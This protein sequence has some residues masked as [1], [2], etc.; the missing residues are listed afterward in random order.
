MKAKGPLG[1]GAVNFKLIGYSIVEPKV[2]LGTD[3][4]MN[5]I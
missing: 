4:K 3:I 2:I 1:F 5:D